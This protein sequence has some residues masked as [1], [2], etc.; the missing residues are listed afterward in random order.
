[1]WSAQ[2]CNTCAQG[3]IKGA[4]GKCEARP[5]CSGTKTLTTG[6]ATKGNDGYWRL[7][8]GDSVYCSVKCGS[9]QELTKI[10]GS[11]YQCKT[12]AA[13]CVGEIKAPL[14]G[15]VVKIANER[16]TVTLDESAWVFYGANNCYAKDDF[17]KGKRFTCDNSQFGDP[18]KGASKACYA[19][20]K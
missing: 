14:P 15:G 18:L 2:N 3:D 17:S 20:F 6:K 8:Q 4:N 10:S 5:V 11:T 12:P 16:Q 7:Q 19:M 13:E 9:G 1:M